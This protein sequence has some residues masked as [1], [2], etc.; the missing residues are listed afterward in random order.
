MILNLI[1]TLKT[2]MYNPKHTKNKKTKFKKNKNSTNE[3]SY[4]SN[5][6]LKL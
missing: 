1:Q 6:K 2:S 3:N 5:K 4:F